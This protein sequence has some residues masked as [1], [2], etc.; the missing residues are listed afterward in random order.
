MT[1]KEISHE[2][3]SRMFHD[4]TYLSSQHGDELA[5]TVSTII[6]QVAEQSARRAAERASEMIWEGCP[7]VTRQHLINVCVQH[8]ISEGTK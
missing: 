5:C 2:L 8:A 6:K 1:E 4:G 7:E 3:T